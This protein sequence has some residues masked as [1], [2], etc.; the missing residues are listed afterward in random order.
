[1]LARTMRAPLGKHGRGVAEECGAE[2]QVNLVVGT[3]SK[4]LKGHRWIR[5]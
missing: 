5:R 2:N 4:S 1:M 3:F